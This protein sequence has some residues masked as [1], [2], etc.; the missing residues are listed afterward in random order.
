MAL[1]VPEETG[2]P[3]TAG[4]ETGAT[5]EKPD[6]PEDGGAAEELPAAGADDVKI[7]GAADSLGSTVT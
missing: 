4:E 1:G 5:K 2:S 3:E 7:D 6:E